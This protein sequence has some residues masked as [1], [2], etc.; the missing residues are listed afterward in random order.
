MSAIS[1]YCRKVLIDY[2]AFKDKNKPICTW[3][4]KDYEV[5]LKA[6]WKDKSE[7]I[8]KHKKEMM[9]LCDQWMDR[10]PLSADDEGLTSNVCLFPNS[11]T[12]RDEED[13]DNVSDET[14]ES[15]YK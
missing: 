13:V 8:P 6:L 9:Q 3:I 14:M 4:T 11:G 7:K 15:I 2:S 10:T 12:V 1:E 5:V